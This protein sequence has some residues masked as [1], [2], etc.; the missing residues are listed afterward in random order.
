M[1]VFL[2]P[3]ECKLLIEDTI[4]A[5]GTRLF[6][7]FRQRKKANRPQPVL[8]LYKDAVAFLREGFV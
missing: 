4:H 6:F 1:D 2:D 8:N 5:K 3:L 7:Q